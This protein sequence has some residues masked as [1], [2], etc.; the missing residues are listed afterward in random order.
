MNDEI[1]EQV[2]AHIDVPFVIDRYW[3]NTG[4]AVAISHSID[5]CIYKIDKYI[6]ICTDRNGHYHIVIPVGENQDKYAKQCGKLAEVSGKYFFIYTRNDNDWIKSNKLSV[7]S[8]RNRSTDVINSWARKYNVM[9]DTNRRGSSININLLL[10]GKPGTGKTQFAVGLAAA[11]SKSLYIVEP[12]LVASIKENCN[13]GNIYM[14]E[15]LDKLLMP[16]GEF[17]NETGFN[18][19][20]V[21]QFLDGALRPSNSIIII[22]CNNLRQLERNEVLCRPGRITSRIEFGNIS[23]HQ[24]KSVCELYYPECDY[25]KVW[26]VVGG[27]CTIAELSTYIANS[28]LDDLTFDQMLEGVGS[29]ISVKTKHNS[30]Y[31]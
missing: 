31:Y 24:C 9:V 5:Y 27:K 18:I 11:I 23:E 20:S 2:K 12:R 4:N 26:S 10:H 22:T 13:N 16:N 3:G 21:L 6:L 30:L 25:T 8:Y 17:I 1:I 7:K 19:D 28:L 29:I 14:I 15:E